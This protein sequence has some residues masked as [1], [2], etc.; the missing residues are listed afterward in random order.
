MTINFDTSNPKDLE[1]VG[2]VISLLTGKPVEESKPATKATK[3][4]KAKKEPVIE[5]A[6]ETD[7]DL[8]TEDSSDETVTFE[9]L[10]AA[11]GKR[12]KAGKRDAVVAV[13]KKFAT[14]GAEKLAAI[15][16]SKYS[17]ALAE[18]EKIKV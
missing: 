1:L 3:Q 15:P 6:G 2:K 17:A 10:Q 18:I 7:D 8:D 13:V 4:E 9:Q 14:G 12:T 11:V 16:E 5:E